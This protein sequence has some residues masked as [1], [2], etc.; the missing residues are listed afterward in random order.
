MA[1]Q[2]TLTFPDGSAHEFE[3]GVNGLDVARSISEGLARAALSVGVNGEVRDLLRPI[4]E[5]GTFAVY[6]DRNEEGRATYWHSSAH[7]MAEA[8]ESLFPGTKF[9]IGPAIENGFYYDVDL[10]DRSLKAEDLLSIETKMAELA[11]RAAPYERRSVSKAD[12]IAYFKEKGDEYKLE[13]LEDLQDGSITFYTQ[14][15]F[16]DL[17]RGPHIPNTKN[18]RYTKLLNIAGAYW[19]G[20]Q[21]RK[22]LTRLYGISFPKKKQLDEFLE[23]RELARERDHRKLGKDLELFT[24]SP[25]VGSGLPLWL[26]KGAI[27]RDTLINFLKEEQLRRGYLPVVTPHIGRLELYKIS[28]HYPYYK[29]SQFP[30]MMDDEEEGYLLKPMNCPHHT[31]IYADKPHSY[32]ELPIR[33]AEFGNVY[34]YEQSGE[35]S[36]LM[37]VR[38]FTIDDA[39]IFCTNEQVKDEFKDVIDLTLKV[40]RMFGFSDFTAQISLRDPQ[41]MEKYV[42]D[43]AVWDAAENAIR[44]ATREMDLEATEEIGEAAFY[45]PKLDFMVR[46]ALGRQWQLGTVQLDY[47]LPERFDLTYIG[48]DNQKHRPVMIHRAPLG[49]LERF[50]AVL[51]EHCGGNFPTWLAPVQVIVLP[52]G[53][54]FEDYASQVKTTL[55]DAGIRVDTDMR[56]EKVSYKIRHAEMQKIPFMLVV[57]KREQENGTVS[58]RRHGGGDLGVRSVHDFIDD[59]KSEMKNTRLE[60]GL[61]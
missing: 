49:S 32:R 30:P 3:N 25:L 45:G 12:A 50:I 38:G 41:D 47:T 60:A 36:G 18:I 59:I 61:S 37:R 7:L 29:D 5:S 14:G 13:L 4:E 17:C 55:M 34:R 33:L 53:Q 19:R 8:L 57:G 44:E 10:G 54:D 51:I 9:G 52:V 6:T 27:L 31:Q 26:P 2:I 35:L 24:F 23:M 58:V 48:E 11:R 20:D 16:T 46:D 40:Y 22:Q 1:E 28:G 42:G 39:H 15:N 43:S 56:N 21:K